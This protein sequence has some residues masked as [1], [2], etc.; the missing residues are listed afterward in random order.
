MGIKFKYEVLQRI[1]QM[2]GQV[3]L[4]KDVSDMGNKL[5]VDRAL[6]ALIKLGKIIRI[7]YGVYAKAEMTLWLDEPVITGQGFDSAC[8]EALNRLQ[9]KWEL[10]RVAKDYNEGRSTQVPVR[11]M[12]RL[13]SR[14]RG[15]LADGNKF[16]FFEGNIN[17][18]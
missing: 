12:V 8:L 9:V 6:A 7:G 10:A 5:R 2:P 3:I 14:F 16:L 11:T 1:E 15:H 17:A 13:K 4:R 18:R